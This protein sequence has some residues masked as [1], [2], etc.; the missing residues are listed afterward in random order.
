MSMICSLVEVD[1]DQINDLLDDPEGIFDFL[2]DL[3]EQGVEEIDLDKAWHGIH[4]LLTG[5][6]WEGT[7]PFCYLVKGGLE[8]G[9]EDFGYGPARLFKPD[10]VVAWANALS[11]ISRDDLRKRFDPEAM[12]KA[13][14][15][16][17]EWSHNIDG[18]APL[19]Y[20]LGYFDSLRS[21]LEEAR[22]ANKGVIIYLS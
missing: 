8:I 19:E 12:T 21:F 20:L 1:E 9:E 4:F 7:E 3:D 5:S 2:D 15:Y 16:P 10:Q 11:K 14:V 18:E 22:D 17:G 6:A 13:E